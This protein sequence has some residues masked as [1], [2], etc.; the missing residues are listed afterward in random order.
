MHQKNRL[1]MRLFL[2]TLLISWCAGCFAMSEAPKGDDSKYDFFHTFSG[3]LP[4]ELELL[5]KKN[6]AGLVLFFST[7]R[8]HFCQ[9]MKETVFN[10]ASVQQYFRQR[11]QLIDI[12][13]ESKQSVTDL[14]HIQI[15]YIGLAKNHHI[16]L[17]PTLVFIDQQG[18][19]VYR[20]V[21]MIADPQ[22]F[23]WLGEYVLSGQSSEQSF[24]SF[25]VNKRH[26]DTL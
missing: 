26:L 18:D 16:R 2:A 21:G 19:V 14:Q 5:K 10:Q 20:H 8:C 17:T 15:S 3:S 23:I 24:A 25:K 11:F 12:D 13:I 7:Q 1:K 6:K 22:E 9:R 4:A